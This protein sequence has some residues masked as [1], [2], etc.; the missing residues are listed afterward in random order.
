MLQF[1]VAMC[2]PTA[3]VIDQR[4]FELTV[5]NAEPVDAAM[6][7]HFEAHALVPLW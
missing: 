4:L 3:I 6:I 5:L 7:V 1:L 2:G